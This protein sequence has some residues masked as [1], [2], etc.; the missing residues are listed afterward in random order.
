MI[1]YRSGNGSCLFGSGRIGGS[2]PFRDCMM[3]KAGALGVILRM[4]VIIIFFLA[5][6]FGVITAIVIMNQSAG[7]CKPYL[8]RDQNANPKRQTKVLDEENIDVGLEP[9]RIAADPEIED[10]LA[11][12]N[13]QQEKRESA[14]IITTAHNIEGRVVSEYLGIVCGVCVTVPVGSDKIALYGW[15]NG[16]NQ[17][18]ETM[19]EQARTIGAD[20]VIAVQTHY[21]NSTLCLLGTAVK[22]L[23]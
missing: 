22:L 11:G 12:G 6:I 8:F 17:A 7:K 19:E 16:V 13:Y 21:I 4:T 18:T 2:G 9:E 14:M 5:V 1:K 10:S 3:E 23:K 20:A 15:Q